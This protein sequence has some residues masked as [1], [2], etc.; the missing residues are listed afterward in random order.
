MEEVV[1]LNSTYVFLGTASSK[2]RWV[3]ISSLRRVGVRLN[4][5]CSCSGRPIAPYN[6]MV[7]ANC[8]LKHTNLI[9]RIVT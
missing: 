7:M 2:K 3:V 9:N 5:T 6:L 8:N 4:V 1:N